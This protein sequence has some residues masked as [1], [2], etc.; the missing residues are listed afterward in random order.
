M[1]SPQPPSPDLH[2]SGGVGGTDAHFEDITTLAASSDDL[3]R[4][5]ASVTAEC[6]SILIDPNVVASA[7]LDPE[8]ATTFAGVL[9]NALDGPGGLGSQA[10]QHGERAIVLRAI[11]ASYQAVDRAQAQ[12]IDRV[13]WAAGTAL[14]LEILPA[15]SALPMLAGAAA[16][17]DPRDTMEAFSDPQRFLTDH[18]GIVDNVIGAGPGLIPDLL[19]GAT[20]TVPGA[21]HLLGSLYPDG[22]AQVTNAGVDSYSAVAQPPV[23]FDD[24][25]NGLDHRNS[26]AHA[27]KPDQIDVRILTHPDGTK[28]YIVD[29]P[30]TKVWDTPGAL[31]PALNDLGTNVHVLGGDVTTRETAIAEALRRAGAT[32]T[33]PVML[34]GHSQGGM[35]AAQ[36][37]H[38]TT[39]G[40]FNYNVTHV[41]TAGAPIAR[42][43]VPNH[44]QVMAI[45]NSHDIVPHLDAAD[46][47]D[48]PNV[49]TVTFDAQ[50][51]GIGDNH[52]ITKSY[53]PA[54]ESLD[55]STDPS[56]IAYRSSAAKA[57]LSNSPGTKLQNNVYN[58]TRVP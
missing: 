11:A 42:T 45:E 27:G 24:L 52:S 49:T 30:G 55:A 51:G 18:P 48:R 7:I 57:F 40:A 4:T 53:V 35:V 13:R 9:L 22:R 20:D 2:I 15:I 54:S 29:I 56:V 33:D 21:A 44:I 34:I 58:L 6:H 26:A 10:A 41:L 19:G 17:L 31:N 47:P 46:N 28:S 3:A 25:I 14:P 23:S 36:A 32:S 38:D 1:T 43:E 5:L 12:L 39:T 37:A 8:G 16:I 50:Y